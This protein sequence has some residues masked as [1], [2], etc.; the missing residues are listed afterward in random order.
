MNLH[1]EIAFETEICA[2]LA[3]H[4]WLYADGDAARYD[5]GRALFPTDVLAW[6]QSTQPQASK[7]D[8]SSC[9][10]CRGLQPAASIFLLRTRSPLV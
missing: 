7:T 4:G 1:H 6:V 8:G 5:R 3:A 9:D 10:R 2:H